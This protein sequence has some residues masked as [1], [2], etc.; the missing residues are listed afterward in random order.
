M[1][2]TADPRFKPHVDP[3]LLGMIGFSL[4]TAVTLMLAGATPDFAHLDAYCDAHPT[5]VMSCNDAPGGGGRRSSAPPSGVHIP[6]PPPLPVHAIVLLDPYGALFSRDHLTAVTMP[7][8]QF[9]PDHSQL[10]EENSAGLAASLPRQQRSDTAMTTRV[11][12]TL[13]AARVRA[14]PAAG[15]VV[16]SQRIQCGSAQIGI[17]GANL[18]ARISQRFDRPGH[19]KHRDRGAA[20]QSLQQRRV[21]SNLTRNP[22][23][24]AFGRKR[25]RTSGSGSRVDV[26]ANRDGGA[27]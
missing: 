8:L 1:R 6:P 2:L 25:T 7:V 19:R 13:T 18:V 21:A 14:V 9:R 23:S 15:I 22:S 5:D 17:D 11:Q 24:A 26:R 4:G 27:V 3:A 16:R 10:G 12:K 20:S